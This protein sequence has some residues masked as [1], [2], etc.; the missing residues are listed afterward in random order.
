MRRVEV[1]IDLKFEIIVCTE[2]R[3]YELRAYVIKPSLTPRYLAQLPRSFTIS[4]PREDCSPRRLS[5]GESEAQA[6]ADRAW[7]SAGP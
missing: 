4:T 1:T 7:A 5:A 6:K 3:V 2:S